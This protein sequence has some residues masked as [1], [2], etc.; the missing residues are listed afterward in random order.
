MLVIAYVLGTSELLN[1]LPTKKKTPLRSL[2]FYCYFT[3]LSCSP[4]PVIVAIYGMYA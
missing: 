2:L 3:G 4:H 1:S